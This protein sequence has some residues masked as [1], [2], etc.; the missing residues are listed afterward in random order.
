LRLLELFVAAARFSLRFSF[1]V[2]CAGFFESRRGFS[3]PFTTPP[4]RDG[5]ACRAYS[6]RRIGASAAE[7][8]QR[9]RPWVLGT[10]VGVLPLLDP[11]VCPDERPEE[12]EAVHQ[13]KANHGL[14]IDSHAYNLTCPIG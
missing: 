14:L 5:S 7:R 8:A 1:R 13:P 6:D 10:L 9:D 2:F 4:S 11:A 12:A 3:A